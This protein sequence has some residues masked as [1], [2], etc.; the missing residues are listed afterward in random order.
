MQEESPLW[1][2]EWKRKQKRTT[3][4][5]SNQQPTPKEI[6]DAEIIALLPQSALLPNQSVSIPDFEKILEALLFYAKS[7]PF[8]YSASYFICKFT[9]L[10]PEFISNYLSNHSE[11][12]LIQT[13]KSLH[14]R[15]RKIFEHNITVK[16]IHNNPQFASF[17]LKNRFNFIDKVEGGGNTTNIAIDAR[18]F[19]SQLGKLPDNKNAVAISQNET[20]ETPQKELNA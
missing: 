6:Q 18:S 11:N 12:P 9:V 15:A 8:A 17:Y 5:D 20:V 13:S 2:G 3:G 1:R 19:L 4:Q 10:E 14:A 7:N 16:H